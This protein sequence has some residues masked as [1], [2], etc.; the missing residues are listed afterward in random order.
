MACSKALGGIG[1][2]SAATST[3]RFMFPY[4]NM[5]FGGWCHRLDAISVSEIEGDFTS[6]NS[7]ATLQGQTG[8]LD[9]EYDGTDILGNIRIIDDLFNVSQEYKYLFEGKPYYFFTR[10]LYLQDYRRA[11]DHEFLQT[12]EIGIDFIKKRN[13]TFSTSVGVAYHLSL[14]HI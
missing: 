9:I 12:A 13:M 2:A 11:I 8:R 5:D 4:V 1:G 3:G 7:G 6:G 10:S 14:I